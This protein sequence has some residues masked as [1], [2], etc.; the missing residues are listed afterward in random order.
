M[1]KKSTSIP[2][3]TAII[4]RVQRGRETGSHADGAIVPF[5]DREIGPEI[6]DKLRGKDRGKIERFFRTVR[7]QFLVEVTDT[8][9]DQLT[10][11]G[12]TPAAG[13][14]ELN[15]LFTAWV[16][17]LPFTPSTFVIPKEG[18][19]YLAVKVMLEFK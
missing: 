7:D 12:L 5:D 19:K 8:S 2:K 3:S 16:E 14:L 15:A 4:V 17:V 18:M 10:A 1:S 6:L 11:A 9:A 13:L